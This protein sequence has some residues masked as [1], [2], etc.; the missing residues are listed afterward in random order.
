MFDPSVVGCESAVS[1]SVKSKSTVDTPS[2]TRRYIIYTRTQTAQNS[3]EKDII[4]RNTEDILT[5]FCISAFIIYKISTS[6]L[7]RKLLKSKSAPEKTV[8]V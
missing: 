5:H 7:H 4:S 6:S 8:F 1:N 2:P 3:L